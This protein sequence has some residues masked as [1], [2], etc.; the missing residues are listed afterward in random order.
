MER[1]RF[2]VDKTL[3]TSRRYGFHEVKTPIFEFTKVF[4]RTLGES[5]DIVS[6]EMYTFKDRGDDDLCLRPEGTAGIV[7]SFLSEG[8]QRKTPLKLF[9]EGPMF[10]YERPQKGRYRQ[11]YQIGVE[12]IG[13]DKLDSDVEV[14]SLGHNTLLELGVLE[15]TKLFVNSIGDSETRKGYREKLVSYYQKHLGELSKDSQHRLKT[16]P[17]RILDSKDKNDIQINQEAPKLLDSLTESSRQRFEEIQKTLKTLGINFEVDPKLVRGLDYYSDLVFEFKTDQLGAQDAVLSGGRYDGLSQ[18]MGG[19]LTPSV[20]WAAGIE[21]LSL[22]MNEDPILSRPVSLIPIGDSAIQFCR[23]LA[24][25]WRKEG[26]VVDLSYGGNMSN[27][28][29]KAS[30][31][32]ARYALVIGDQ[33][34]Q[35]GQGNL[36]DLDSGE[37]KLLSIQEAYNILKT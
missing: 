36:K 16:N 24:H 37:Q 35:S 32:K 30:N 3:E 7:R 19:P 23:E 9:Y 6:K 34:L 8:L 1:Y 33:E 2:I 31:K 4:S 14:L 12:L 29:K 21:R 5:T 15:K 25:N 17:L 20:G 18:L 27:R 10:R 22:L 28:L 13:S 26:L 11:F